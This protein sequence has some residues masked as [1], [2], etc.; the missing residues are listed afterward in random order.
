MWYN[1]V[2]SFMAEFGC[3]GRYFRYTP[4]ARTDL[5]DFMNPMASSKLFVLVF[6]SFPFL[7]TIR[8]IGLLWQQAVRWSDLALL[9]TLYTLNAFGLTIGSHRMLPHRSFRPHPAVKAILL[10]LGS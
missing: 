5:K 10:V 9:V 6:W 2:S 1:L 3:H 7:G 4:A 8:A